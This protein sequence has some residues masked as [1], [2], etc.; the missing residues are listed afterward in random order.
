MLGAPSS[1]TQRENQANFGVGTVWVSKKRHVGSGP[2]GSVFGDK[3]RLI[4]KRGVQ[5][6]G[7][8]HVAKRSS[9]LR[10]AYPEVKLQGRDL[11]RVVGIVAPFILLGV[12]TRRKFFLSSPREKLAQETYAGCPLQRFATGEPGKLQGRY[13]VG[14][15]DGSCGYRI[16]GSVLGENSF[17][18]ETWV[19]RRGGGGRHVANRCSDPRL[20]YP[21]VKLQ[22]RDLV[23]VVGVVAPLSF[24]RRDLHVV[25]VVRVVICGVRVIL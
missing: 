17:Y 5:E 13:C 10:Q 1:G 24:I 8:H 18:R 22:R 16:R 2:V 11:V 19:S 6:G 9:D 15:V 20:A 21:E 12:G 3:I 25:R 7:G 23:R 4:E 14:I